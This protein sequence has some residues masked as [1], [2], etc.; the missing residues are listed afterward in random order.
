MKRLACVAV[1]ILFSLAA[2]GEEP[3]DFMPPGQLRPSFFVGGGLGTVARTNTDVRFIPTFG[4]SVQYDF[5]PLWGAY[6]EARY[7]SRGVRVASRS[8]TAPFV[9]LV[10]AIA[11]RPLS[12]LFS[13][14][15]HT[16][17]LLGI[18]AEIP[19]GQLSGALP[20]AFG[21]ATQ[22]DLG[23]H[24]A[25]QQE[26]PLGTAWTL[27]YRLWVTRGIFG[28]VAGSGTRLWALDTGLA[29]VLGGR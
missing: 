17:F 27:G 26:W 14:R 1:A 13:E 9:D 29:L 6:T 22:V 10:A 4:A 7:S 19:L 16:Q 21:N 12:D 28:I 18:A 23:L 25:W 24:V 15:V 8:A 20:V 11:V 2:G 5:T 3:T